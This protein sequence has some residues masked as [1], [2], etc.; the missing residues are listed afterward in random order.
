VAERKPTD[1]SRSRAKL[2]HLTGLALPH[3]TDER[4]LHDRIRLGLVSALAVNEVLSFV[5]LKRLLDVSDGN[6]SVHA[7][8]LE[9]AELVACTKT[10]DGRVPR[11]EFRLT[12]SG[13]RAL[14][15]HL[16]HL[17]RLI[18]AVRKR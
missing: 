7:R 8:K 3:A 13:R 17:E 12:P 16:D 9:E 1:R 5:E 4:L 6:L 18:R 15:R 2:A 14:E 11:T 10:F